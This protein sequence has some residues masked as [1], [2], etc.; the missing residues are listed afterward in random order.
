MHRR[1]Q[2]S[3]TARSTSVTPAEQPVIA[4]DTIAAISTPAGEGAIALVRIA[5]A[6][7]I[8]IANQIFRGQEKPAH[9]S[10]HVQHFGEVVDETDRVVDEVM[11]SI[12][13]APAS[14]TGEDVGEISCHGGM[15]V[16][17]RVLDC[18]LRAGARVRVNVPSAPFSMARWI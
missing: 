15:L 3:T 5:G 18:C 17:A 7:S 6:G 13:R 14:Y 4:G 8:D 12:H 1:A 10:S 2:R 16:T 11:M 9:F